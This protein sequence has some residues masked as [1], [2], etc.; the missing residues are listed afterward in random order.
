MNHSIAQ[1]LTA[2]DAAL[3][4][5][6]WQLAI[7]SYRAALEQ[8][9][10]LAVAWYNLAYALRAT[11]Q[12][13][14]ALAAYQQAIDHRIDGPDEAM[15]SRAAIFSE[16][17]AAPTAAEAELRAAI[18]LNP[19][20]LPALLNLAMLME[21]R[22]DGAAAKS[23]YSHLLALDPGN[24]RALLRQTM[25]A[26]HEGAAAQQIPI[27]QAALSQR[28]LSPDERADIGFALANALDA[29]GQ[30]GQAWDAMMAAN[31]ADIASYA[32]AMRYDRVRHE[33]L[34]D[35]LIALPIPQ[36][37]DTGPDPAP[38]P[39]FICG[40]FRSGS[41]LVEHILARHSA[42]TAGGELE[43]VPSL[44]ADQIADY[45]ASLG[46]A[47]AGI[48]SRW[49]DYYLSGVRQ[50]VGSEAIVTDKRCDNFM[51]IGLIKRLFPKAK[52]IHT[53]RNP[54]DVLISTLFLRFGH[55]VSY[56]ASFEDFAHWY[57]QYQRLM[58]HWILHFGADIVAF[59]YDRLVKSPEDSI[60]A[61]LT[62]LGLE[63]DNNC[64]G[65]HHADTVRVTTASSWQVRQ[66]VHQK[67]SGRA[68]A[69]ARQLANHRP[70]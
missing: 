1:H 28:T 37:H 16:H 4:R 50:L 23:H 5:G 22:G 19:R 8:D 35:A 58:A 68:A 69:Y 43:L 52:I 45:P 32:P 39:I 59:D 33:Q 60:R 25:I 42:I 56:G 62:A 31:A 9:A 64:L 3:V 12:Y 40:L 29:A 21:D 47:D 11:R 14:P 17:L 49:R 66:P 13:E 27:L 10:T 61:L 30:Y 70:A 6:D 55:A 34:V 67:S 51:H 18:R 48:L 20:S 63:W 2:A 15:V 41:T 38:E 57:G 26:V 53:V 36:V 46:A 44:V 54:D 65:H 24:A 7:A